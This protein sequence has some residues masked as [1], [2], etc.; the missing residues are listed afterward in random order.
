MLSFM[1][2]A[3]E[4]IMTRERWTHNHQKPAIFIFFLW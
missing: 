2:K 1:I 3:V 4:H